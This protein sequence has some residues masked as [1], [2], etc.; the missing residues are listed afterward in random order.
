[1]CFEDLTIE[2]AMDLNER[3][4]PVPLANEEVSKLID[5]VGGLPH[6]VHRGLYHIHNGD[7]KFDDLIS[8]DASM[9]HPIY[10]DHLRRHG[11]R[12][13]KNK[14]QLAVSKDHN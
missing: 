9:Y 4:T 10:G 8:H 3:F 1:M 12:L 14:D 2:Q 11:F 6:L 7:I 13:Q 5:W